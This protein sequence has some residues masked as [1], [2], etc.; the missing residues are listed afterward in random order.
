ML[1]DLLCAEGAHD[2]SRDPAT[3]TLH[4]RGVTYRV[5]V[6]CCASCGRMEQSPD[7][8]RWVTTDLIASLRKSAAG[9]RA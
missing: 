5:W 6:R 1:R 4:V 8:E 7:G 3:P 9:V 2:W